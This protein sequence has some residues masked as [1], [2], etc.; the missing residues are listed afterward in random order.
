[1]KSEP[2]SLRKSLVLVTVDCLRADHVGFMGY[3]TS[4]TPFLD[5]IA[6]E[7]Y[8]F[9]KAVTAGAPTYF[10]L[11]S[12]LSS[13]YPLDLGRDIVGLA[14]GEITLA[15]ALQ[16]QGYAT[17]CFSAANPY[18][19]N[20][21]GY[22]QGFDVFED[23]LSND[24][25]ELKKDAESGNAW[26]RR[27][28]RRV[29]QASQQLGALGAVYDELYFQYCQ[30]SG[31]PATSMDELRRFPSA[32]V[33]VSRACEWLESLKNKP[34]FL[35]LHLM[36]PHAP[37][38]PADQA[39]TWTQMA[40]SPSRA[41]YLNSYWNRSDLSASRWQNKRK[42]IVELYD[43]AVYWVD[44]QLSRLMQKLMSRQGWHD[45]VFALTADHGE[46]F[47][48]HEGRFHFPNRL[49]EELIH[50]PL[51]VRVPERRS[52][53]HESPFSLVDLG[54]TLL[55]AINIKPPVEFK[56]T[57]RWESV[58]TLGDWHDPC[59]AEAVSGCTNPFIL[60]NRLR[61]RTMAVRDGRYKMQLQFE[62]GL[63]ELF[64]L[65]SDPL[66]H[67]P[68][69]ENQEIG[70]RRRLLEIAQNHLQRSVNQR[71][72]LLRLRSKLRQVHLQLP[73]SIEKSDYA[74]Q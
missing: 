39:R 66:E 44:A 27:L 37:Y 21:F 35:W 18:V 63:W 17:A 34:F 38:Y 31:P 43:A 2:T 53:S 55:D 3:A 40:I 20:A 71:D 12:I 52:R 4:T 46:E 25:E 64:D 32:D 67:F 1:M 19:S 62:T 10:S 72:T 5:S 48:D 30:R 69:P 58:A 73:Q 50:V 51:L 28:N 24:N 61:S 42:E 7:S 60:A 13:R 14:P 74:L 15:S 22:Q 54:P 57:S 29:A 56:G 23:F 45:C 26:K 36:D 65:E 49:N 16:S 70:V 9:R 8:V 41:R 11:P 6:K 33:L 59:I 47:L 68:I